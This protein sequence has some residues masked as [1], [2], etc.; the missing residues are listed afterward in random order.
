MDP[1]TIPPNLHLFPPLGMPYCPFYPYYCGNSAN[2]M[3]YGWKTDT[4]NNGNTEINPSVIAPLPKK[5]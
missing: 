2:L 5:D 3:F 1:N 4:N